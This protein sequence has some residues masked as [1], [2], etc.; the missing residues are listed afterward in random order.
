MAEQLKVVID[1]D[2]SKA[3]SKIVN[4]G[5]AF[6][7]QFNEINN[8]ANKLSANIAASVAKINS[9]LS[10]LK[11][12]S[13]DISVN[14]SELDSS[15]N[16]IKSKFEA[17]ADPKIDILAN[18]DLAEAKIKELLAELKTLKGSEIF[19]RANDTQALKVIN[20]VEA[21]LNSLIGKKITIDVNTTQAL[22]QIKSIEKKIIDLKI[23]PVDI[24]LNTSSIDSSLKS[25]KSKFAALTNPE[26]NVLA[27][28]ELAEA[29]IKEL[30]TELQSLKGSEIFISAN[31][32]QALKVIGEVEAELNSLIGKKLTIDVNAS[33]ALAEIKLIET[34]IADLQKLKI[35]PDVSTTQIALFEK[36]I[37]QLKAKL[38]ELKGKDVGTFVFKADASQLLSTIKNVE[39]AT[40]KVGRGGFDNLTQALG[41][42]TTAA[43]T[44]QTKATG[45]NNFFGQI[46]TSSTKA[47][48]ALNKLPNVSG[49]ATQSLVNLSRVAQDA[50]FGF[51]GIANNI[52][53]LLESFQR[54]KV[55]AKETGTSVKSALVGALTGP[56]G[57]GLAVGVASSLLLS[58]GD[59]LLRLI[60]PSTKLSDALDAAGDALTKNVGQVTVYVEALK[61]GT[62]TTEQTKKVQ[63]DLI[64][65]APEFQSAFKGNAVNVEELDRILEKKYIPQLIKSIKVTAAFGIVN[66]T[67]A[68]SIK[69][70]AKGGQDFSFGEKVE[71][72]LA[73]FGGISGG[74]ASAAK[75]AVKNVK[76]AEKD[77]TSDNI[78]KLIEKTFKSL[79]I[80]FGDA[81]NTIT[82]GGKKVAKAVDNSLERAR[83]FIK[84]FGEVFVVPDLEITFTN[85]EAKVKAAAKKL[86]SDIDKGLLIT[87]TFGTRVVNVPI[88][89]A[90]QVD[91]KGLA[92]DLKTI[93]DNLFKDAN[94]F[95][96]TTK[97]IKGLV[98]GVDKD[99]ADRNKKF[100]DDFQ[101]NIRATATL[102][103]D[104]LSPAFTG[105]FDAIA[106]GENP[107]KAF[108]SGLTDAVKQLIKKLIQAAIQAA[109]LSALTGGTSG[110]LGGFSKIFQGF[111]GFS[112]A[113]GG[114]FGLG[115]QIAGRSFQNTLNVVVHGEISGQK[116][117]LAGQR[118]AG[119]N[120]R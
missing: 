49:A 5:K 14:T 74:V 38:N 17:L 59:D 76:E 80:T 86:L 70:I 50:P 101:Q 62:L 35:S 90:L 57:V 19:I 112:G 7:N 89:L 1:A 107:L 8:S 12:T 72:F 66:E 105:M 24:S 34:E 10:S 51:L 103:T 88:E 58:F 44:L 113:G 16:S 83:A 97:I 75:T 42:A 110:A 102:V 68:K 118:A 37:D 2:V 18:T 79:G 98:P 28:T 120:V 36:N 71:T 56:A 111:L 109:V 96:D 92:N 82:D 45:L 106:A 55:S 29:K 52:N 64:D 84:Q 116:I 46:V 53:P 60:S 99:V 100:F 69:Q 91:D 26:I 20:E 25:I 65:Q 9:S 32:V 31:D 94:I 41:K 3:E 23:T 77:L 78:S 39:T 48:T 22:S 11:V 81:A 119:S 61:S 117:L 87:K 63:K 33:K 73:G 93:R 4:F 104:V 108:F 85:T 21:E 30:L 115:G 114:G 40:K 27:N 43:A 13:V 54:L 6:T 15:I 47:A 67:L 95:G